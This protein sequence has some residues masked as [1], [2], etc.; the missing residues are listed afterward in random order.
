MAYPEGITIK[1]FPLGYP[2][3]APRN[4]LVMLAEA[5]SEE[6]LR[7]GGLS[8]PFR[9]YVRGRLEPDAECFETRR[10]PGEMCLPYSRPI[11]IY[12]TEA[13]RVERSTP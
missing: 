5:E 10:S 3:N 7:E 13:D 8:Q 1:M 12:L 2:P 6:L 9:V 11:V 4:D